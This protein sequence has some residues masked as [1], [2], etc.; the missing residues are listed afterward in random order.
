MKPASPLRTAA[1]ATAAYSASAATPAVAYAHTVLGPSGK[2]RAARGQTQP[3]G[4]EVWSGVA[5]AG[6][7]GGGI[8][9]P[10]RPSHRAE[11]RRPPP[12]A[13][14]STARLSVGTRPPRRLEEARTGRPG[15]PRGC[16]GADVA[17]RR[18]WEHGGPPDGPVGAMARSYKSAPT[19]AAQPAAAPRAWAAAECSGVP[20]PWLRPS[21]STPGC[22][23][24]H[25]AAYVWPCALRGRPVQRGVACA[26]KRAGPRFSGL[27]A[28]GGPALPRHERT[29]GRQP[30]PQGKLQL[31]C[32]F[33]PQQGRGVGR[34]AGTCL[35]KQVAPSC[36]SAVRSDRLFRSHGS[37]CQIRKLRCRL[38]WAGLPRAAAQSRKGRGAPTATNPLHWPRRGACRAVGP[39]HGP[40]AGRQVGHTLPSRPRAVRSWPRR[41]T[42]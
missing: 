27:A 18:R 36:C 6:W 38:C 21:I 25:S 12:R 34:G 10:A 28:Q 41:A 23:S 30:T 24:S 7:L 13:V 2:W 31:R 5:A 39:P 15:A 3:P 14:G 8:N 29:A 16:G 1:S 33:G 22:F 40:L 35:I 26:E 9:A 17:L 19:P 11:S 32:G 37:A 4:E 20:P 42:P